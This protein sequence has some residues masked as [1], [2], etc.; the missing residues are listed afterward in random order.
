M[1]KHI[2]IFLTLTLTFMQFAST[3][4]TTDKANL[5]ERIIEVT[6]TAEMLI[7]PNEYTFKIILNE[8]FENKETITID[9]QENELKEELANIGINVQ[10]DLTIADMSSVFTTRRTKKDVLG[11]KEYYLKIYDLTKIEKLQQIADKLDLG[12]LDLVQVTHTEL[13]KFRKEVKI[14]AVRMA[15]LKAEY[16][17]EAIGEKLGKTMLIQE[18]IDYIDYQ[19]YLDK[20]QGGQLSSN[21]MLSMQEALKSGEILS[22]SKIKLKYNVLARFEIK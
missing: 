6:G 14:E 3:G 16:M 12:K 11:D 20:A 18:I 21:S 15:K 13:A 7:T 5:A 2:A 22:F 1:N 9:K 10:K 4:Q 8:R 19:N 17:L